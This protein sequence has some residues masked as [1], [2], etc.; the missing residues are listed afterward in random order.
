MLLLGQDRGL[1][2]VNDVVHSLRV[3]GFSGA[4]YPIGTKGYDT[5]RRVKNS[6]CNVLHPLVIARP[7]SAID[8]AIAL[9]AARSHYLPVSVRSGGHGYTCNNLKNGSLHFDM[10][11]MNKVKFVKGYQGRVSARH[12]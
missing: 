10:R 3:S 7:R 2:A 12:A 4:I 1:A 11:R 9:A 5:Y 8:V 6:A